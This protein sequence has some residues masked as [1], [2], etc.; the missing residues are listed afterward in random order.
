MPTA[1]V[2]LCQ[3]QGQ[4]G[5][6]LRT[7]SWIEVQLVGEDDQPIGG[8]KYAILL[9]GGKRVEGT[10]DDRGSVRLEGLPPGACKVSFPE[11]DKDAWT[12]VETESSATGE[13]SEAA[14]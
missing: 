7:R 5:D 8:V 13:R 11:L 6:K 4:A 3:N 2:Q 1:H 10:L 9:P 12:T 14:A